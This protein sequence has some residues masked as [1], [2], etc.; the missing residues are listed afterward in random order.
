[1]EERSCAA[2]CAMPTFN[3][4]GCFLRIW[5]RSSTSGPLAGPRRRHFRRR[6]GF[7]SGV[8]P[9][10]LPGNIGTLTIGDRQSNH[11]SWGGLYFDQHGSALGTMLI[12]ISNAGNDKIAII[13]NGAPDVHSPT[14]QRWQGPTRFSKATP[15]RAMARAGKRPSPRTAT[16]SS[17]RACPSGRG[18]RATP[19]P[20]FG[21]SA[22]TSS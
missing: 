6:P 14:T 2:S 19:V 22:T 16:G 12:D 21:K 10:A 1:M 17:P 5:R 3:V 11:T 18:W 20:S 4:A 13:G 15:T 9:E 8:R 7:H